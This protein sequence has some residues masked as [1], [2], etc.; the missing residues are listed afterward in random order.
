MI[1]YRENLE[2]F[3]GKMIRSNKQTDHSLFAGYKI[4]MQNSTAFLHNSNEQTE[5]EITKKI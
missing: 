1:L 5:N 4:N 2:E 3:K